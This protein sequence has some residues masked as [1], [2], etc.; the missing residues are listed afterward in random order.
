M[1][2]W[3]FLLG[4][5]M[6]QLFEWIYGQV[7]GFLA[8]FF[9]QMGNMGVELFTI[10]WVQ[11]IVLFFSYL[12]WVLYGVQPVHACAGGAVQALGQ[13]AKQHHGR[14]HQLRYRLQWNG[15][16]N[17]RTARHSARCRSCHRQRSI[18]RPIYHFQSDYAALYHNHDALCSD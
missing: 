7:V 2:I 11:S 1:F 18:W 14:N 8:E 4:D 15:S 9:A 3:Y 12:D 13:S 16:R 6:D 5:V 10:S 17:H